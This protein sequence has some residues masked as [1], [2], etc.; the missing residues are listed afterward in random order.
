MSNDRPKLT[1]KDQSGDETVG[2]TSGRVNEAG[3]AVE[4]SAETSSGR[5][6]DGLFARGRAGISSGT[7]EISIT[8]RGVANGGAALS[9]SST[10]IAAAW[11][12]RDMPT[13]ADRV[14]VPKP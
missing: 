11:A 5:A 3:G 2:M 6:P 8:S 12:R 7:T 4:T 1:R 14:G 10:P 13:T 9:I